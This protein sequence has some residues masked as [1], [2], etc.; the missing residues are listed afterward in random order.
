MTA[1]ARGARLAALLLLCTAAG[2]RQGPRS[3]DTAAGPEAVPPAPLR[4]VGRQACAACHAEQTNLWRG[5]DH[6]LAM[7]EATEETVLGNFRDASVTVRGVESRFYRRAGKFF[8]RTEGPDGKAQDYPVAYTFGVRPLQQY[9]LPFPG[10]RFQALTV[11]WDTRPSRKGGE[12]WFSLYPDERIVPEDELHW[13]RRAQNWNYMCADCHSTNLQKGYDP[14]TDTFRTTWS[15]IEVACEA[16]HGPGSRHVEQARRYREGKSWED[17]D[18]KG[19]E[20][21]LRERAGVQWAIDPKTGLAVRSLPPAA[22][23]A[24]VE[25]C[26]PCH[27]RRTAIRQARVFGRP[28]ADS[29]RVSLLEP[30]LYFHDGQIR[31]EVY[32]YGSF[33]QSKM[34]GK[35]VTCSDCHEPH[36]G[37]V[38]VAGNPLCA[39][40]HAAERFDTPEHHFHRTGSPGAQCVAC[41]MPTRTYM[42]VDPRRDHS[43]RVPRPDL[44]V[45][46][47][48]PNACNGCHRGRSPAWAE[49]AVTRWYGEKRRK[50]PDFAEAFAA[51]ERGAA[52]AAAALASVA[53]SPE[54][55]SIVR[56][57]ALALLERNFEP[58]A[59]PSLQAGLRDPDP[60]VRFGAAQ[61]LEALA[62]EGCAAF[63][64]PLLSDPV[65]SVRLEA[66]RALA[67]V[68]DG[69][70]GEAD[71]HAVERGLAEY[72]AAQLVNADQ[73]WAH[74]NLGL[75]EGERGDLDAAERAYRA[76]LRL[77]SRFL[78]AYLNLADLERQRGREAEGEKLLREALR[79]DPKDAAAHH[80]LGLLFVR[81]KRMTEALQELVRAV[82]LAPDNARYGYVLAVGLDSVRQ[83]RQALEALERALRRHPED[84]DLLALRETWARRPTK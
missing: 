3:T 47:G 4:F 35:G 21:V 66:A 10:G 51:A 2:C 49:A 84:R 25:T 52:G 28:L 56:A 20:V 26:A 9:L 80:A 5:S 73:P 69:N 57:T 24:E 30:S 8:I 50:G 45:R 27:A 54:A 81:Q 19:L 74:L 75:V 65:L 60:L 38:R 15:E 72:R 11:A 18:R 23:R 68:P 16:C 76:A 43:L 82:E 7:Q 42:V 55:P 31:D 40:C 22:F 78:P 12:R 64:L 70:L 46:L 37:R 34:F 6:A 53:S 44:T 13:T 67:A 83:R 41:H 77:D 62:P 32:E 59:L 1:K 79:L 58:A 36:R 29:Y 33:L 17:L 71:R 14:A 39:V 48:V 61:A 63:A